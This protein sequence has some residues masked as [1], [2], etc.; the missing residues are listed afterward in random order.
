LHSQHQRISDATATVLALLSL[1]A[2]KVEVAIAGANALHRNH[3]LV[4]A[5]DS[6]EHCQSSKFSAGAISGNDPL[7]RPKP[8]LSGVKV[9]RDLVADVG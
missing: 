6:L 2:Q 8:V 5:D 3:F 4:L 7:R 1:Y 9:V